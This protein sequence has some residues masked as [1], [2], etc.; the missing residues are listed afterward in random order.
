MKKND[1]YK[2]AF[3]KIITI[4]WII[5]LSVTTVVTIISLILYYGKWFDFSLYWYSWPLS[6][7]LGTMVNLFAFNLLKN[8]IASLSS[9]S[10]IA[11]ST[12]NYLI[13][14]L[15]YGFALYIAINNEK[16]NTVF[17]FMGF[18]TVRIAIYI[19]SF[20]YKDKE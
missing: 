5:I 18:L 2:T 10:N 11:S 7:L 15:I 17:V 19:Y 1:E 6:Y 3:S 16:L 4:S 20:Q 12:S 13:R 9:E 14:L 8:N